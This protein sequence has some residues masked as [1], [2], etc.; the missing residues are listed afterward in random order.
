MTAQDAHDLPDTLLECLLRRR[1][2]PGVAGGE[3]LFASA[4]AGE[5]V[6]LVERHYEWCF[7]PP[8]DLQRL[9]GLR[10]ESLTDINDQHRQGRQL[11]STCA[12]SAERVVAR[13]IDE[14]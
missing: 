3:R 11:T 8:Q 12:Q 2:L 14:E 9:Y 7:R 1:R 10:F 6:Q 13:R 4:P 5:P